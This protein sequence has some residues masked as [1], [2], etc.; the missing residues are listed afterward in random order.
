MIKMFITYE[1]TLQGIEILYSNYHSSAYSNE[2]NFLK[3]KMYLYVTII[4]HY[5]SPTFE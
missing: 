4:F 3:Y 1:N 5:A 2:W